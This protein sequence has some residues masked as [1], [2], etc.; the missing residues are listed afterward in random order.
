MSASFTY[1]FTG[2]QLGIFYGSPRQQITS[3]PSMSSPMSRSGA[4]V[5]VAFTS[6]LL[7]APFFPFLIGT[8]KSVN[9]KG[10]VSIHHPPASD[11]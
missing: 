10:Y 5:F 1:A 8:S 11:I 4:R 3:R 2:I 9:G 6:M 7:P